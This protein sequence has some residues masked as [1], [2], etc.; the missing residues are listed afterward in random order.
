MRIFTIILI[1]LVGVI[2]F[3]QANELTI[4]PEEI[5]QKVDL[6]IDPQNLSGSVKNF[7]IKGDM[8]INNLPV[9]INSVMIFQLPNKF[10]TVVETNGMATTVIFDGEKGY[11][12]NKLSGKVAM[13]K[14]DIA[15]T[16]QQMK[17]MNVATKY[18]KLFTSAELKKELV[19]VNGKQCYEVWGELPDYF[20]QKPLKLF[21]DTQNFFIQSYV[22][23]IA[24]SFGLI[25]VTVV[26]SNFTNFS[27]FILPKNSL[28]KFTGLSIQ[29]TVNELT[30]NI[31]IED[32]FFT[33]F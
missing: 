10:K 28:T 19:E 30:L 12:I 13:N 1:I 20:T 31:P 4:T 2:N 24:S 5:L 22:I 18:S 32:N 21:I 8:V 3:L 11:T 6:A 9:E 33:V 16:L 26:N 29:N 27:D 25:E 17:F 23:E 15:S 14:E 7:E